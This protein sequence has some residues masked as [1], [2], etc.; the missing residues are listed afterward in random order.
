MLDE[1]RTAERANIVDIKSAEFA[2]YI[3][4]IKS[5][6]PNLADLD[7]DKICR[8]QG[9]SVEGKPTIAGLMLFSVYPQAFFPQ[10]CITAVSVPGTEMSMTGSVGERFIDNKRIDGTI[11]QMLRDTL[12]FVRKNMK[13]KTIVDNIGQTYRP[14]LIPDNCR[15]RACCKCSCA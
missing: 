4:E 14:R 7:D 1:L 5:K 13:Q 10:L 3:L 2:K 12:I 15:Q 11:Q 9:F 6:K 8:L